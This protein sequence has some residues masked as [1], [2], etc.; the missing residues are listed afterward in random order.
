MILRKFSSFM[1]I[2]LL[3]LTAMSCKK[4][5]EAQTYPSLSGNLYFDCPA[6]VA[7]EQVV[8]LTPKGVSHPDG[9]EVSYY[10]KISPSMSQSDTV[11]VF[12]RAFSDTLGRYTV[13][14]HA[15]ASGYTGDSY[16][17]SVDVVKGGLDGSIT[18][19]GIKDTDLRIY[20]EGE[21]YFVDLIGK[22]EWFR[23]NLATP[24]SG[25]PY[26]NNDVTSEVFGR[27][28][29]Y[30]E[31]LT[32]CPDGWRLPTEEDWMALA[33]ELGVNVTQKYETFEGV[34]SKILANAYYNDV[35]MVEYW[36]E[37]GMLNNDSG[38]SLL[39]VGYSN[40]GDPDADGRYS[41]ASFFG[42]NNY[43]VVWTAD[44]VEG[45][46]SMAYYRYL[47]YNQPDMFV[48]KA[49]VNSFGAS[50]RCVRDVE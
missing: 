27:Y 1:M 12:T 20:W 32:A 34:T 14:C 5:D 9:G 24:S 48:G 3:A 23:N 19:T 26:V 10:W 11:D 7:P 41:R 18:N 35:P 46:E 40:L 39:P 37:V 43:A 29:S 30:E 36:P 13:I 42:M 31:A 50:V 2:F 4:D 22:Y 49:D 6:Y 44:R 25:T 33:S 47:V 15:F 8:T 17:V 45:D 28:Y 16:Q 21:D 38:L